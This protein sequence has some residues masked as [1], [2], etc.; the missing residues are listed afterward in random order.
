LGRPERCSD[1]EQ[2]IW[3]LIQLVA[4]KAFPL[5]EAAGIWWARYRH[6]LA[7]GP[8]MQ[9]FVLKFGYH[10]VYCDLRVVYT[11]SLELLVNGLY[12]AKGI[13]DALRISCLSLN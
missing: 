11:P 13:V 4:E 10:N 5:F 9:S 2:Q 8:Q 6:A 7:H 12:A 3:I 1:S